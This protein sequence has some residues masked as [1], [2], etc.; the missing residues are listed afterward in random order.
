[1]LYSYCSN[2]Y[3]GGSS[4]GGLWKS[5]PK[6]ILG[7]DNYM[8]SELQERNTW[9]KAPLGI[10]NEASYNRRFPVRNLSTAE[11]FYVLPI[12]TLLLGSHYH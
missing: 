11:T 9:N 12:L 1:M 4:A 8:A 7:A 5:S 2:I 3:G 6:A 10:I